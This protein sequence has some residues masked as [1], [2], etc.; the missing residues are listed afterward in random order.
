MSFRSGQSGTVVRKGQ[1]WHGR[2]YVDIPN[3]EMRRKTSVPLGSV[4]SMKK[5]EA[6]R[7]LRAMLE[8]IGLNSDQHLENNTRGGRTFAEE[9]SWWRENR[10]S[11]FKPSTQEAMGSHLDKYLIPRFGA[12]PLAMIDDRRVQEFIADMT[13]AKY[14]WPNGVTRKISPKTIRNIVGVLKQIL[15]QKVWRDWNLT[16]PEI[17]VKEQR[18]FTEEEMLKIV[19][20]TEGQWQVLFATLATTGLRC[21]E[22]FGLYVEDLDLVRGNVRV[23]RSM[24]NGQE[25]TLK[26]KQGYRVVN[27]EPALVE[28]LKKHLG[29]RKSGLVFRTRMGTP[30]CKSNVRRKLNRVLQSLKLKPAGLHAFRHG[31]VSVLQSNNVPGDLVKEWVGHSSLRT[32][33]RY[34][35]FQDEYRT[36]IANEIGLFAQADA[37]KQL[38]V[39]PNS[40]NFVENSGASVAA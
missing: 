22:S 4:H 29:D 12:L 26:T 27:I 36:R 25:G 13:R 6:K 7:K 2:Y 23:Q 37:A 38:P 9:A 32:T 15:G 40:P 28:M 35:H 19:N 14:T 34:T 33:S 30:F 21:G 5:T 11:I 39:S 16:V 20:A 18:Y 31:R 10:L 17:P 24:W 1:M 8:E 3:Q